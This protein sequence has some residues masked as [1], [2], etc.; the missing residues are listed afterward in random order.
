VLAQDLLCGACKAKSRRL[1]KYLG[2]DIT[3]LYAPVKEESAPGAGGSAD[4]K[5]SKSKG[6]G[7]TS[8]STDRAA[9]EDDGKPWK[10]KCKCGEVCSSYEKSIFHPAGQWYECSKCEVWSHVHCNLGNLTPAQVTALP[11][12]PLSRFCL[13][14]NRSCFLPLTAFAG[15]SLLLLHDRRAP[16]P[17]ARL[18]VRGCARCGAG[19]STRCLSRRE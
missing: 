2:V 6:K 13:R 8:S 10:F 19:R 11:V 1:S 15:G 4:G 9:E 18:W 3:T 16:Q 7:K 17:Q 14:I 12:R 5:G